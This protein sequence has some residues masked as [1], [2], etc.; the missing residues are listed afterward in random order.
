MDTVHRL[1]TH[2]ETVLAYAAGRHA[3]ETHWLCVE[4][5]DLGLRDMDHLSINAALKGK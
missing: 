3:V 1:A 5:G 4:G 2:V